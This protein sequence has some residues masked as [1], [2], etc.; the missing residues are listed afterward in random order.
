M[1]DKY[2]SG[3][4]AANNVIRDLQHRPEWAA[5]E[6]R[7]RIVIATRSNTPLQQVLAEDNPHFQPSSMPP[8][9]V[10]SVPSRLMLRDLLI[11]PVQRI[12]RYPLVLSALMNTAAP[13]S[14]SGEGF[15]T[16]QSALDVGVDVERA[17]SVMQNSASRANVANR[18]SMVLARTAIIA[19]RLEYHPV[20]ILS[21]NM[22]PTSSLTWNTVGHSQPSF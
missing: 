5:F 11:L 20:S 19:R 16:Y 22:S 15:F 10:S 9:T 6:K 3:A 8:P 4:A 14:P 2:C 13:P 18:R 7:C 21:I 12:C 1:Y 17:I